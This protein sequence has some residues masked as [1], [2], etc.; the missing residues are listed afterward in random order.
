[1]Y[2]SEKARKKCWQRYQI[3]VSKSFHKC[4]STNLR[5]IQRSQNPR[6][7]EKVYYFVLK[8]LDSQHKISSFM[9]VVL[10]K[11]FFVYLMTVQIRT[12]PSI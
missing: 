6:N 3:P 1:M 12:R 11:T 7:F 4:C 2:T 8:F 9:I 5:C 10:M